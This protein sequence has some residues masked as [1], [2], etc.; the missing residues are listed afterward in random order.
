[1]QMGKLNL[2][3]MGELYVPCHNDLLKKSCD[4][5]MNCKDKNCNKSLCD[6]LGNCL[7]QRTE[8]Y[9]R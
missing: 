6:R 3:N 4:S 9:C 1:M 5:C 8:C 7:C 2:S